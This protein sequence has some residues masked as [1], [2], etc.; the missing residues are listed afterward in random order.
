MS[1]TSSYLVGV[2]TGGT[3]TDAAIIEAIGVTPAALMA[4]QLGRRLREMKFPTPTRRIDAPDPPS[5]SG[6]L[7]GRPA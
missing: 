6:L 7:P 3:Y 4:A 2:D 1:G 5:V